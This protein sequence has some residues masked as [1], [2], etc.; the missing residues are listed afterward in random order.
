[1]NKRAIVIVLDSVGIGELPDSH[2]YG[3]EG[4]NTLK[5]TALAVGGLK[6]PNMQKLGLGNIEEIKGVPPLTNARGNY[7]KMNE[8]SVGKDTTTGHWEMMGLILEKSFPTYPDGFPTDVITQ[9]EKLINRKILGNVAASG[10]EI[11]KELGA[12]HIKTGYPIVYT[13]ADSVFQ[14]AAHEEIIPLEE[15][16]QICA[17][18]REMLTGEHEVGRVIARPF[19]GE[20]GSFVR[21]ANRQD[22]TVKPAKNILDILLENDLEVLGVGKIKNIYGGRG[23]SQSFPTENNLDGINRIIK[24]LQND[25]SG[26]LFA[27]L[28]D[29]DQ[30]Y[31]HRNNPVG[32]ANALAEFDERL[33]QI[34]ANLE[35]DDILIITADHGCDPT[36]P[37]TDHSRE[38]VPLLVYGPSLKTNVNLGIRETFA[39][40]GQ[41]VAEHLGVK[42]DK[43]LAG[44]SFY[45]DV[46]P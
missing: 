11:I 34:M 35:E 45:G 7:G 38:Y 36:T 44:V 8:K 5:N 46:G 32:Y 30:L 39:D 9:Y 16:Y 12:Q 4:A 43:T 26:L 18:A 37:G 29:F 21:T 31:G 20:E 19:V 25:F 27:N 41:T 2:L 33:P 14:I 42:V 28:V 40:L 23:V 10:T 13:S 24:L 1:M 3:D 22:Y 17:K 15:L 6:L